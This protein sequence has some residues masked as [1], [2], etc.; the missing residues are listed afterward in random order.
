MKLTTPQTRRMTYLVPLAL[1]AAIGCGDSPDYRDQRLA[2]MA[3]QTVAEQVKQNSRMADQS[4]AIVAES[5]QL[6]EA[7]KELVEQDAE[8]R[9][10]LIAAQQELTTT[11]N[12][13]FGQQKTSRQDWRYGQQPKQQLDWDAFP[14]R[15]RRKGNLLGTS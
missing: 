9:R 10:E 8:A 6:A 5:H 12:G 4:E 11:A 3:Q 15:F 2:E 13:L 14:F 7:A 1:L